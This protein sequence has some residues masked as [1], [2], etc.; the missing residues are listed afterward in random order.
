MINALHRLVF[1]WISQGRLDQ[2]LI[3]FL[4]DGLTVIASRVLIPLA[5]PNGLGIQSINDPDQRSLVRK[6]KSFITQHIMMMGVLVMQIGNDRLV[7][8]RKF[9]TGETE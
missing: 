5:G 1:P 2:V 3:E 4:H 7:P 8:D 6:I 9:A